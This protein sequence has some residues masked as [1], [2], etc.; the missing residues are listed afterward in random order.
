MF[1]TLLRAARIN[2][3][4][5]LTLASQREDP[6]AMSPMHVSLTPCDSTNAVMERE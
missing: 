5:K 1:S 3:V 4:R 2:M 6:M